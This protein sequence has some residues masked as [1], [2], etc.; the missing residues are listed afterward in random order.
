[1]IVT[2]ESRCITIC[3]PNAKSTPAL[4]NLRVSKA[5]SFSDYVNDF[6]S[7]NQTTLKKCIYTAKANSCE[8]RKKKKPKLLIKIHCMKHTRESYDASASFEKHCPREHELGRRLTR[9]KL[10]GTSCCKT[11]LRRILNCEL[12][13]IEIFKVDKEVWTRLLISTA[14]PFK[15][16]HREFFHAWSPC[17]KIFECRSAQISLQDFVALLNEKGGLN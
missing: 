6:R 3:A 2:V 11:W 16:P 12:S 17:K 8:T 10:F 5:I 13:R 1:M 15:I 14:H 4:I 9:T 7:S